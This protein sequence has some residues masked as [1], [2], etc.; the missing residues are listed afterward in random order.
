MTGPSSKSLFPFRL[1]VDQRSAQLSGLALAVLLVAGCIR[2]IGE[3]APPPE[4]VTLRGQVVAR[5]PAS[6]MEVGVPGAAAQLLGTSFRAV[7]DNTGAF[8]FTRVP[9]GTFDLLVTSSSIGRSRLVADIELLSDGADVDVPKIELTEPRTIEGRVFVGT[10]TTTPAVGA[11]IWVVG[12]N[13]VGFADGEG[14]YRISGVPE[15]WLSDGSY[16]LAFYLAGY[17]PLER[18]VNVGADTVQVP[19][20]Q[21]S[22]TTDA[23]MVEVFGNA[24]LIGEVSSDGII[25]SFRPEGLQQEVVVA[26]DAAG[27]YALTLPPGAYRARFSRAGYGPVELRGIVLAMGLAVGLRPVF[28]ASITDGDLDDDG[29]PDDQDPDR[30]N[31]GIPNED[32]PEPDDPTNGAGCSTPPVIVSITPSTPRVASTIEVVASSISPPSCAP[33]GSELSSLIFATA[34][35]G[36]VS[37]A[38]VGDMVVPAADIGPSLERAMFIVPSTAVSGDVF[39]LGSYTTIPGPA[40]SITLLP[41]LI[42]VTDVVPRGGP[43]GAIVEI[44]GRGFRGL[45]NDMPLEVRFASGNAPFE[46][47]VFEGSTLFRVPGN[48]P[49][50]TVLVTVANGT[51]TAQFEFV[52]ST[53]VPFVDEFEPRIVEPGVDALFF[54]GAN[55]DAVTEVI[56]PNNRPVAPTRQSFAELAIDPVPTVLE[57]GRIRLR[58]T[59]QIDIETRRELAILSEESTMAITGPVA[60]HFDPANGVDDILEFRPGEIRRHTFEG[61]QPNGTTPFLSTS[62]AI[63]GV[64]PRPTHDRGVVIADPDGTGFFRPYVVQFSDLSIRAT[65][66]PT[67]VPLGVLE[68]ESFSASFSLDE[69]YAYIYKSSP[70]EPEPF[71][72]RIDMLPLNQGAACSTIPLDGACGIPD[73]EGQIVGFEGTKILAVFDTTVERGLAELDIVGGATPTVQCIQDPA[74]VETEALAPDVMFV[75][76][77]TSLVWMRSGVRLFAFDYGMPFGDTDNVFLTDESRAPFLVP[78]GGGRW[79]TTGAEII[80]RTRRVLAW[81][82]SITPRY[83]PDGHPAKPAFIVP[84]QTPPMLKK[85]VLD[86]MP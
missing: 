42:E 67:D 68:T 44:S 60:I 11:R 49:E 47:P 57:P 2:S 6:G 7:T 62:A 64:V 18:M 12:T 32:D 79:L 51:R 61:F 53:S 84:V 3:V 52:V 58:S 70:R 75:D 73:F 55:L 45:P 29:I 63:M 10:G 69:R 43:P 50:G 83:A 22:L 23:G 74:T 28:L 86:D 80:D 85:L 1:G 16:Q 38:P 36:R 27:D 30:D 71:V 66:A 41:S 33:Q 14:A 81:Q 8:R 56:L 24:Q 17:D 76:T 31:D 19:D 25:V 13:F 48:E 9:V 21:L 78:L 39:M 54:Y 77:T 34:D 40:Q 35:G 82:R 26:T 5:D 15:P 37:A 46:G 59:G 20:T 65:C 4:G 72:L